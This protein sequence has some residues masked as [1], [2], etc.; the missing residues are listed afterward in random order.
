[1]LFLILSFVPSLSHANYL[2]LFYQLCINLQTYNNNDAVMQYRAFFS[3]RAN[4]QLAKPTTDNLCV[5]P[6]KKNQ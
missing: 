5:Q 1:M 4:S 3:L 2:I 6:Q